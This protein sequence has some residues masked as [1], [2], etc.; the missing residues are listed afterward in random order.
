MLNGI[1]QKNDFDLFTF[2]L[3]NFKDK[4]WDSMITSI[5]TRLQMLL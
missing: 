2:H 1:F 5:T 3:K 4:V